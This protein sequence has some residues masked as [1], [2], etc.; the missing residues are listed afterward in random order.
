LDNRKRQQAICDQWGA[1]F[2]LLDPGLRVGIALQTLDQVPLHGLRIPPEGNTCGW[3]FRAGDE[4]S[5]D[6]NF[7]Q[8]LC[9]E[10]LEKYCPLAIP[11]LALPPGWRFLTDGEYVDVWEDPQL[12]QAED[13]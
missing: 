1:K 6:P 7:F 5:E 11:F 3:Y 12:L 13:D 8:P 4:Y 2:T 10:H 9:V